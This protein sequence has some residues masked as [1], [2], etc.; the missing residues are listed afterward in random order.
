MALIEDFDE[1]RTRTSIRVRVAVEAQKGRDS[2]K[3]QSMT[4]IMTLSEAIRLGSML[5]PQIRSDFVG[6]DHSSCAL[7]AAMIA[8]GYHNCQGLKALFPITASIV[9]CPSCGDSWCL[10]DCIIHLNDAHRWTRGQI[11]DWVE[12]LEQASTIKAE[13]GAVPEAGPPA[14]VLGPILQAR[15]S[16]L[17]RTLAHCRSAS[18]F[19]ASLAA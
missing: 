4:P 5:G 12:T 1:K 14:V 16:A 3:T 13:K 8:V 18:K 19:C 11:A 9:R 15:R 6:P 7:G 2:M 10:V 17:M